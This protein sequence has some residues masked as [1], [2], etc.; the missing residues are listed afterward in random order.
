MMTM[1][2][3]LVTMLA[4]AGVYAGIATM[5]GDNW[6]VLSAALSGGARPVDQPAA[7]RAFSRA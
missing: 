7:S 3:A 2:M 4:F 1:L 5:L 6:P